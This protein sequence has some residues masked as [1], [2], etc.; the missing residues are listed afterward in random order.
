M[1]AQLT[2]KVVSANLTEMVLDV[3]GVGYK[4]L[5]PVSTYDALPRKGETATLLTEMQVREDAINLYGFAKEQERLIFNLLITVNGIGCKTALNI[6]SSMNIPS[7]CAALSQGDVKTLKKI[8]GV[9]PKSA[10]RMVV[11]LKDKISKIAP[12]LTFGSVDG[13]AV[14][15]IPPE[16]EDA[17][18]A[19]EQLGF[20]R[21]KI[22]KTVLEIASKIPEKQRTC[23]N[24]I[25]Q[26]LQALNR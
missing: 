25:R 12:E 6:L 22:E 10:E 26:S 2:G 24:I 9:G 3:G 14:Q 7:F 11:E 19:L 17:I 8:N 15:T 16:Q 21:T 13:A 23:E 1:I 18:I 4:L 5:I 20:Q